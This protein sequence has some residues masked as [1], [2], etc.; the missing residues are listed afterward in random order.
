M[1]IIISFYV[2]DI[3]FV[4][5]AAPLISSGQIMGKITKL[6]NNQEKLAQT[7]DEILKYVKKMA[8]KKDVDIEQYKV[9]IVIYSAINS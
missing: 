6:Q 4:I 3:F 7:C 5:Q 9:I 8:E 2:T 1:V